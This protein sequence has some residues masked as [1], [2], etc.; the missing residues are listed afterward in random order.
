[1]RNEF[2]EDFLYLFKEWEK[3]CIYFFLI[4]FVDLEKYENFYGMFVVEEVKDGSDESDVK[5]GGEVFE[6]EKIVGIKKE[7]GGGF[8]LKVLFVKCFIFYVIKIIF[9]V[10]GIIGLVGEL[11]VFL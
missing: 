4:E 10:F 1:M 11:W 7:E 6:V 3:L 8:Y 9:G 2:V 5:D